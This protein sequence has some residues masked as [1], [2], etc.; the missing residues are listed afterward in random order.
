MRLRASRRESSLPSDTVARPVSVPPSTPF[1]ITQ[2]PEERGIVRDRARHVGRGGTGVGRRGEQRRARARDMAQ[3]H[4]RLTCVFSLTLSPSICPSRTRII[5]FFVRL[6]GVRSG[7]GRV[8]V[9]A[10]RGSTMTPAAER[11]GNEQ[12]GDGVCVRV[13]RGKRGGGQRT[14]AAKER[15]RSQPHSSAAPWCWCCCCC[16][17]FGSY[18]NV[19]LIPRN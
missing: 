7:G 8:S 11:D 1:T 19:C 12:S 14:V 3:A 18:V 16:D 10:M 4:H 15:P 9:Q 5:S 2:A 6:E 17:G 13:H